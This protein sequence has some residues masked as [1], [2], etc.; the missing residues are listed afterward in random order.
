[1]GY[2][3]DL[4]LVG[5]LVASGLRGAVSLTLSLIVVL[6]VNIDPAIGYLGEFLFF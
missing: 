1:M 3:F 5:L 4:K 2:G 6:N